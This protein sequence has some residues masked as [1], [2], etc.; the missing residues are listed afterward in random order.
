MLQHDGKKP[1]GREIKPARPSRERQGDRWKDWFITKPAQDRVMKR[2]AARR[3]R[4]D[5]SHE[6][7]RGRLW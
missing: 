6:R 7:D 5:S 4:Q 2:Q 3:K 1:A